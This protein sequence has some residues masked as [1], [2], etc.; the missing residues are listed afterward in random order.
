M[1]SVIRLVILV[2]SAAL[3]TIVTPIEAGF[4]AD[5]FGIYTGPF[6]QKDAR[7]AQDGSGGAI[8]VWE[9]AD[10]G[11][12]IVAQRI[13]SAGRPK[14]GDQGIVVC[15]ETG[16]QN[17][18]LIVTDGSGGAI[19]VWNDGRNGNY[20]IYGQRLDSDGVIQWVNGGVG[21]VTKTGDQYLEGIIP[22]GGGAIVLWTDWGD[23]LSDIK[24]EIQRIDAGGLLLWAASGVS[25][26]NGTGGQEEPCIASC[27]SGGAIV[28]W[29]DGR[30]GFDIYAQSISSAGAALWDA[31]GVVVC[32][33]IEAQYDP[34]IIPDDAG[35]VIVA[36]TDYRNG[37]FRCDIYAQ[38][39]DGS[40]AG[41]WPAG[42]VA[43]CIAPENQWCEAMIGDGSGGAII[44][45][46]DFQSSG[47]DV[48]AQRI[49]MDGAEL[50]SYNGVAVCAASGSQWYI[51]TVSDGAGGAIVSWVDW[52]SGVAMDYDIYA[53][54]VDAS[55]MMRWAPDGSGIC[56]A[57]DDQS[58]AE[59]ISDGAGGVFVVWKDRRNGDYDIYAS[60]INTD[61]DPV[62]TLLAACSIDLEG[63]YP[64]L[65]W[66]LIEEPG[67]R[68]FFVFRSTDGGVSFDE[69]RDAAVTVKGRTCIF[70]DTD[71]VPGTE[72]IYRVE[73]FDEGERTLLLEAGPIHV[74][75][76]RLVLRQNHPNPFNP[77]TTIEYILPSECRVLLA[78][79]DPAGRLVARL[80]DTEQQAGPHTVV[81]NGRGI[82]GSDIPSGVYF[83]RLQAGKLNETRKMLLLR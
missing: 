67:E 30:G 14:W 78:V 20:D 8:I 27:S 34:V 47:E 43:V 73:M 49:D 81:W 53:Q 62:A 82:S 24:V 66:A 1:R 39:L 58:D 35:G 60:R 28:A 18:P 33:E 12:R 48:Y 17:N 75:D 42:G 63:I 57:D 11:Y 65:T 64:R 10:S 16:G 70:V 9:D 37:N 44:A 23:G 7:L 40:G 59:P 26:S 76:L 72:C 83:Y 54:R 13:D 2:S 51:R 15:D 79:Y 56:M 52:R 32:A 68:V 21:I 5:G 29:Q 4:I 6:D 71:C 31:G 77:S 36:W 25:V 38:R 69:I 74:P 80:V 50:W 22:E 3:L 45:W 55:G 41:L 19:V 46:G 61:G